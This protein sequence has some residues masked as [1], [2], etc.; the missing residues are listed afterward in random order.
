MNKKELR[1]G[2]IV[3]REYWN[4]A[5]TGKT[6]E[7]EPCK[8]VS[9]G[10]ENLLT[11]ESLKRNKYIKTNYENIKPIPLTEEW[12]LKFGFD[13]PDINDDEYELNDTKNELTI[14]ISFY[15]ETFL[16]DMR[17]QDCLYV[18]HKKM[19]YVHQL[20]NFYFALTGEELI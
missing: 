12:L 8:I 15:G 14:R 11:T 4:P 5:P 9:L 1:I 16:T 17:S 18:R 2:N 13:A 7:Y 6:K 10:L 3:G 19:Q 20:Q